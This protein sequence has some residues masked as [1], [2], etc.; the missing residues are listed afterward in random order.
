MS[1]TVGRPRKTIDDKKVPLSVAIERKLF[2]KIDEARG[3]L[4]RSVF[5]ADIIQQHLGTDREVQ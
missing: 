3:N 1:G 5:V 4:P 2:K